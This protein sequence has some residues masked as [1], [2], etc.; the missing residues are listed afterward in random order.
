MIAVL[1]FLPIGKVLLLSFV[2]AESGQ[3]T[4]ANYIKILSHKY[5]LTALKNTLIVGALGMLGACLLGIPLAYCMSRYQ[6]PGKAFISTLAVLALV[7]PPFIGAYAWILS[8]I[9]I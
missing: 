5:Y 4:L 3:Y 2:D 9:H 8:L 1:L 6:I 7:S